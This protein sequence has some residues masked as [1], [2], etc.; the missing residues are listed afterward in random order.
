MGRWPWEMEPIQGILPLVL[1]PVL[2]IPSSS[3]TVQG[4][5]AWWTNICTGASTSQFHSQFFHSLAG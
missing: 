3:L 1:G 2:L 5:E 4:R